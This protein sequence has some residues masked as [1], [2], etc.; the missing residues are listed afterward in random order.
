[1]DCNKNNVQFSMVDG[2]IFDGP[3]PRLFAMKLS[4][5]AKTG[6]GA[7]DTMRLV[8]AGSE[9][10][11]VRTIAASYGGVPVAVSIA[12]A[13]EQSFSFTGVAGANVV[14]APFRERYSLSTF[15]LSPGKLGDSYFRGLPKRVGVV[16]DR[17][18]VAIAPRIIAETIDFLCETGGER[19]NSVQTT[20][21]GSPQGLRS[22]RPLYS[23]SHPQ[24]RTVYGP[25]TVVYPE[26]MTPPFDVMVLPL[27]A[28]GYNGDLETAGILLDRLI[29][30]GESSYWTFQ[31]NLVDNNALFANTAT[32]GNY[33][34]TPY[35]V[36]RV[37]RPENGRIVEGRVWEDRDNLP[38]M[39]ATVTPFAAPDVS[40][41]AIVGCLPVV[42]DQNA[43]GGNRYWLMADAA[44]GFA[45]P[46]HVIPPELSPLRDLWTEG[47]YPSIGD[48]TSEQF[49]NDV[50]AEGV[51]VIRDF[52]GLNG[53]VGTAIDN[54]GFGRPSLFAELY[55]YGAV[56]LRSSQ[57]SHCSAS[58]DGTNIWR[59][60]TNYDTGTPVPINYRAELLPVPENTAFRTA[61]VGGIQFY[62]IAYCNR[63]LKGFP[64]VAVRTDSD[65]R[66]IVVTRVGQWTPPMRR[67]ST[68]LN[69]AWDVT[70]QRITGTAS[71]CANKL[72]SGTEVPVL[73]NAASIKAALGEKLTPSVA[74]PAEEKKQ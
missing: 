5:I 9:L 51:R 30:S 61:E 63:E 35:L 13:F 29:D 65:S 57:T 31:F 62:P 11:R 34:V 66:P 44:T 46:V 68:G 26:P 18:S 22:T 8:D 37:E 32:F 33:T 6:K 60:G 2:R 67:T 41:H 54:N 3:I 15:L 43:D 38:H 7:L 23:L 45:V 10:S 59:Y 58:V 47:N 27:T 36:F 42:H 50:R 69:R 17:L 74:V 21:R 24:Y 72:K 70:V 28:D 49:P 73:A 71:S 40:S 25:D 48:G 4:S 53:F 55:T 19:T 56:G 1:M 52:N 39:T 20:K 14:R 64:G 12:F 16:N